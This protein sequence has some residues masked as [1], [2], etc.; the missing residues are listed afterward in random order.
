MNPGWRVEQLGWTHGIIFL[1]MVVVLS[2]SRPRG[3]C[4]FL[5]PLAPP[6]NASNSSLISALKGSIVRKGSASKLYSK[7]SQAA[8]CSHH[9][10]YVG[11][12]EDVDRNG[13]QP[14]F[15]NFRGPSFP[16]VTSTTIATG[17]NRAQNKNSSMAMVA[18]R[19]GRRR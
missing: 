14:N 2:Y 11:G 5:R 3:R 6:D 12:K 18:Y 10:S 8:F 9:Q 7:P 4:A 19:V 1:E 16:E 17:F 13:R 15:I